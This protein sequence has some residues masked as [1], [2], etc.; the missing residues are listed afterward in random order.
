MTTY[1]ELDALQRAVHEADVRAAAAAAKYDALLARR[2]PIRVLTAAEADV[3]ITAREATAAHDALVAGLDASTQQPDPLIPVLLMPVRIETRYGT[4]AAGGTVLR[5]RVYPDDMHFDSHRTAL[6]EREGQAGTAYWA[7]IAASTTTADA[8]AAWGTL[9]R[10]VGTARAD[11]VAVSTKPGAPAATIAG[12]SSWTRAEQAALLPDAWFAM[13][14]RGD[15]PLTTATGGIIARPL[16]IGP[17]PTVQNGDD[18]GIRWMTDFDEAMRVGMGLVV[19]LPDDGPIDLLTV[20]G[21]RGTDPP[22]ISADDFSDLLTAHRYTVGLDLIP[23]G[24]PTNTTAAGA[25]AVGSVDAGGTDLFVD[26]SAPTAPTG[27]SVVA[28]RDALGLAADGLPPVTHAALGSADAERDMATALWPGTWGYYLAQMLQ[29]HDYSEQ[30]DRWRQWTLDHVR[31]GGPLPAVRVGRQP[32]GL[33]PILP[34]E[35]WRPEGRSTAL[36][37]AELGPPSRR[38]GFAGMRPT[39]LRALDEINGAGAWTAEFPLGSGPNAPADATGLSLA[40]GALTDTAIAAFAF[41][42]T[43]VKAAAG[44]PCPIGHLTHDGWQAVGEVVV[45]LGAVLSGDPQIVGIGLAFTTLADSAA[46]GQPDARDLVAVVQVRPD[47]GADPVAFLFVAQGVRADGSV[48]AWSDPVDVSKQVSGDQVV[49]SLAVTLVRDTANLSVI[50]APAQITAPAI[51]LSVRAARGL[52][53]DATFTGGWGRPSPLGPELDPSI[54]LTGTALVEITVEGSRGVALTQFFGNGNGISG[55]YSGYAVNPRTTGLKPSF[56]PYNLGTSSTIAVA[57]TCASLTWPRARTSRRGLR[58][59]TE[60]ANLLQFLK[61]AWLRGARSPLSSTGDPTRQLLDLLASDATSQRYETRAFL[62]NAVLQTVARALD[63]A[64][65]PGPPVDASSVTDFLSTDLGLVPR[66]LESGSPPATWSHLLAGRFMASTRGDGAVVTMPGDPASATAW[67]DDLLG[68]TP[69]DLHDHVDTEKT[70][71]LERLLR[72]SLLQ[73]YADAAFLAKPPAVDDTQPPLHEPEIV[74]LVDYSLSDPRAVR[75]MTSWRYL[76]EETL[77]GK[78]L[79]DVIHKEARSSTPAPWAQPVVDVLAALTRLRDVPADELERLA[80]NVLD[81]ATYRLDAWVTAFTTE[82]LNERRDA[83][84]TGLVVGAYGMVTNLAK[85][86]DATASTGYVYAPSLTHA[87]TAAVLRSGYLSH[88]DGPLN[89]D[90]SSRRTRGAMEVITAVSQ[91]QS[92]GAV[93]GQRLERAL[94]DAKLAAHLSELREAAPLEVG[95]LTPLP[96]G[97]T[98]SQ[99]AGMVRIDGLTLISLRDRTNGTLPWGTHGLPTPTSADATAMEGLVSELADAVDAIA[100]IGVAEGVHQTLQRN[101]QR[102]AAALDSVSRGDAPFPSDPDVLHIPQPGIGVTH[103]IILNAPAATGTTPGWSVG[104][105]ATAEPR[106]N[107]LLARALPDPQHAYWRVIHLNDDGTVERTDHHDLAALAV[108]PLDLL[109]LADPAAGIVERSDLGALAL[110]YAH[111]QQRPDHTRVQVDFGVDANQSPDL[112]VAEFLTVAGAWRNVVLSGRAVRSADL[113]PA[114]QSAETGVSL[115]AAVQELR[116]RLV[117]ARDDLSAKVDDLRAPFQTTA[118]LRAHVAATLPDSP[119]V[120]NL[121]DLSTASD[122]GPLLDIDLDGVV[123]DD[124]RPRI[125]KFDAIRDL[126]VELAYFGIDGVLPGLP[127]E[128]DVQE[129]LGLTGLAIRAA[130]EAQAR[131]ALA[132]AAVAETDAAASHQTALAALQ[133]GFSSLFGS[134]FV[135]LPVLTTAMPVQEPPAFEESDAWD[136][137]D[138]AADVREAAGRL[139]DA[140]FLAEATGGATVRWTVRQYSPDAADG[141]AALAPLPGRRTPTGATSIALV[142]VNDDWPTSELAGLHIDSWVEVVPSGT[143]DTAVAFHLDTPDARAPQTALLAVHPDPGRPWNSVV[144]SKVVR[145][146]AELAMVR[147]VDPGDVPLVGHLL[148]ALLLPTNANGDAISVAVEE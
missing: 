61:E 10:D 124:E 58:D 42:G 29:L 22:D 28:L 106:L 97:A 33:L 143:A 12:T 46:A 49:E 44:L 32:Y 76:S 52:A 121:L 90:L 64:D 75:T 103:R 71:L 93:L 63:P 119:N 1:S 24:A 60:T 15:H 109:A 99:V 34:L 16:N 37:V 77:N 14:W 57:A 125:T 87:T 147:S 123:V 98:A 27:S 47:R 55:T 79:A 105:R 129:R 66:G 132:D 43:V 9:A 30:H 108:S 113:A 45:P 65:V 59:R 40:V 83:R 13:A 18:P 131:I 23:P 62:G 137:A 148:P 17:D 86:S 111:G 114:G 11:W 146:A 26:P 82:L 101:T 141:W 120:Q 69:T 21:I 135:A 7:A 70:Y 67:I 118:A 2:T 85:S 128:D 142:G 39:A 130:G 68:A 84:P 95:V 136:W 104:P 25:S 78:P 102:A 145:E 5:V 88:G 38:R 56:G 3:E 80:A 74:D 117:Q 144:L 4:S 20:V 36:I 72:Y 51:T 41:T 53:A 107:A 139:R 19:E 91:G 140:S 50:S 122:L 112:S 48:V 92:L 116:A 110:L 94:Q 54:P 134:G 133:P 89:I 100:D 6:T 73:A 31:G 81:V 126:L 8:I 115:Q 96:S 127:L 35:D 138:Q